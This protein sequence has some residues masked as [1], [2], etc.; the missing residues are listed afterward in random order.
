M[1]T[2]LN[3]RYTFIRRRTNALNY[4]NNSNY[5]HMY[6]PEEKAT[7]RQPV[8]IFL[9]RYAWNVKMLMGEYGGNDLNEMCYI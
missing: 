3:Y 8:P 9:M 6:R 7:Y 1:T 5:S 4:P 2:R